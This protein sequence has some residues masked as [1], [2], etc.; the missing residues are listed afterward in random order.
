MATLEE[1]Q[2]KKDALYKESDQL[3]AQAKSMQADRDRLVE[4]AKAKTAAAEALKETNPS[5]VDFQIAAKNAQIA[6]LNIQLKSAEI[7][8]LINQ[9]ISKSQEGAKYSA[10][11]AALLTNES[12]IKTPTAT[13]TSKTDED[14]AE[15]YEDPTRVPQPETRTV[16]RDGLENIPTV[17]LTTGGTAG[18]FVGEE[19]SNSTAG[20]FIG[21]TTDAGTNRVTRTDEKYSASDS[22]TN[23]RIPASLRSQV[24]GGTAPAKSAQW[25]GAKDLRAT[26]RVPSSYLIGP[27]AGPGSILKEL[28]GILFPYT[29]EISYDTQ[30]SYSAQNPVHSNYTQYYYKNSSVG[31]ISVTGK[32]TVQ[33][34]KEGMI[35][36]GIQHLLRSLTKMRFG[37]DK[38][39]GSPPPVCR[40]DAYGDYM[41]SNVPVVVASFKLELPSGVDYIAVKSDPY[42]TSLVP[43]MA[44]I[45]MT[46]NPMYSRGEISRFSVDGWL[47][48]NLKNRGYL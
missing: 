37:A 44:T 40:L 17:D 24:N 30:A 19:S 6:V 38:N 32:F 16:A 29:P 42:K 43:T 45:N 26:L 11:I 9:S 1:L 5:S 33:N 41:I 7:D 23:S 25:A 28:G 36:L 10:E 39:A 21:E 3:L 20:G 18:G 8:E 4:E 27:A 46:L 13:N 22:M 12:T 15:K 48:G 14:T 31:P 35:L 2:S 47:N 34:E